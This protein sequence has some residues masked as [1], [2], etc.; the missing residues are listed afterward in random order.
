MMASMQTI[1]TYNR[2]HD[3]SEEQKDFMEQEDVKTAISTEEEVVGATM[4]W[5]RASRKAAKESGKK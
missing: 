4:A 1:V 3:L 5:H 2:V